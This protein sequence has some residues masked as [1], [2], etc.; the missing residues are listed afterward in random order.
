MPENSAKSIDVSLTEASSKVDLLVIQE[1][2]RRYV[3]VEP[4]LDVDCEFGDSQRQS[5]Q[6]DPWELGLL[7][8]SDSPWLLFGE[9]GSGNATEYSYALKDSRN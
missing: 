8:Q 1:T 9:Y 3:I 2:V 5:N 7:R 6:R 4:L